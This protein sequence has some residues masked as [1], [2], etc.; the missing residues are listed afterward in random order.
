MMFDVIDNQCLLAG[1]LT[2][3]CALLA[4]SFKAVLPENI[5]PVKTQ[6]DPPIPP[7]WPGLDIDIVSFKTFYCFWSCVDKFGIE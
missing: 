3:A 2:A 6:I 4:Y 7:Q 1:C 5:G